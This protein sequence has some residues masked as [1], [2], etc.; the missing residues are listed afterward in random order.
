MN[1]CQGSISVGTK[2]DR[3]M[4]EFVEH[5]SDRLGVTPAEF[6]RRVLLLYRQSRAEETACDHC[7]EPVVMEL[8]YA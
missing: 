5:E 2:V 7:G 8:T 1:R 3:S 4:R 6:V